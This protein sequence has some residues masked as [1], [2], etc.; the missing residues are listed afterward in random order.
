MGSRSWKAALVAGVV[1]ATPVVLPVASAQAVTA[2]TVETEQ[3]PSNSQASKTITVDCPTGTFLYGPGGGIDG[4]AGSV[5]LESVV[6]EGSPPFRARVT[7]VEL[8]AFSG[9]WSVSAWASCGP[10]T[11]NLQVVPASTASSTATT[12]EVSMSC[13]GSR[14]LYGT[15]F[16]TSGGSGS[17]L[18]HDVIPGTSVAPKSVTARAT[19]RPGLTPGWRLDV[20]GVCANAAPTMRVEQATTTPGSASTRGVSR[21]CQQSG[22]RAHGGGR[23]DDERGVPR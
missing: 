16:R 6:P 11:T 1:V 4:G 7:A 22:T 13:P 2:I 14:A 23:P 15:G 18:V 20:F 3:S 8:G 10:L 12:K 17:V 9:S 19:A 21:V 5:T